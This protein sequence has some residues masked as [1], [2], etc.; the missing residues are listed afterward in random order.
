MLRLFLC[1]DLSL[2]L[3]LRRFLGAEGGGGGGE[4]RLLSAGE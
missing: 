3:S 1:N 2:D 4:T